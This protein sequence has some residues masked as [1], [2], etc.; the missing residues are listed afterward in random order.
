MHPVVE[1]PETNL[2]YHSW[3]RGEADFNASIRAGKLI[4]VKPVE[5]I[6]CFLVTMYLYAVK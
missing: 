3:Y 1:C 4:K 5:E 6:C 2:E